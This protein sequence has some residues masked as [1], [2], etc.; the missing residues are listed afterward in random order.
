MTKAKTLIF[1]IGD[2]KTGSTSIQY[3][4]A[5]KQVQ[6]EGRS[7]FYP[8]KITM[9]M[10]RRH[11]D[12]GEDGTSPK[13]VARAQQVF[14][15][16]GERLKAAKEDYC[17]VSA[18][19]FE[20]VP[21]ATFRETLDTHWAA[22]DERIRVI[23]YVRPHAARVISSFAERVKIG[24]RKVV[25]ADPDAFFEQMR[26]I[27]RFRYYPRFM[28][29][30]EQFGEAF[31]LRPMIRQRL[32]EGDVVKDFV[33]HAFDGTP[34]RLLGEDSA[35]ESLCLEDLMRLKVVQMELGPLPPQLRHSFGW[36][37]GRVL[38]TLPPLQTRTR[39]E[40]HKSLAEKIRMEYREDARAMD[41]DFF[42]G[43]KVLETELDQACDTARSEPQSVR[44]ED[45]LSGEEMRG[46]TV[47]ARILAGV[48][49]ND[50]VNWPVFLH[51]KRV[52]E[53]RQVAR[54]FTGGGR[55]GRQRAGA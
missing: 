27:D 36:E 48:F 52:Q 41:R 5:Q 13:A 8:A 53:V 25:D 47:L 30:R 49:E 34:F 15:S 33:H 6:L 24:L 20:T 21:A 43:E 50:Q 26:E 12:A 16:L 3:A 46:I 31:L 42:G 23:A 35:N 54:A 38:A 17:L 18:E 40:L 22:G 2:H 37:F 51:G 19:G 32:R 7:V 10:L 29:W 55:G 44:P 28:A 9:N 45:Y 39:L 14:A 1:H 4:F 11:F